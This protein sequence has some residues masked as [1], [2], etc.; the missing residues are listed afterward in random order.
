MKITIDKA[1]RVVIPKSLR[2]QAHLQDGSTLNITFQDGVILLEPTPLDVRVT[3]RDGVVVAVPI[4]K[5]PPL[6]KKEVDA[7]VANS[8]NHGE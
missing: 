5:I 2:D 6:T 3:T 8:R 1:G 4:E 7:A